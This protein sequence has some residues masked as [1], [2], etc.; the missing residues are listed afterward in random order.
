MQINSASNFCKK[1]SEKIKLNIVTG[2]V[3]KLPLYCMCSFGFEYQLKLTRIVP[4]YH[5][6]IFF[7]FDFKDNL[8]NAFLFAME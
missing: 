4:N 2:K 1:T 7:R 5:I 3:N 8:I 6:S